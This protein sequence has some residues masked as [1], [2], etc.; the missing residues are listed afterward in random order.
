MTREDT[1]RQ[2]DRIAT[3]F[4]SRTLKTTKLLARGGFA[5]AK[6][7]LGKRG[8]RPKD[9][10]KQIANAER[11]LDELSGL[12][13]LLMKFGQMASYLDHSLPPEAQR[14]L[15]R[16]QSDSE[17]MGFESVASV[18][19]Q[20]L[21]GEPHE[22]FDSFEE[23]PFAAASIGQVHRAELDGQR[24]AVKVQYPGIVDAL[25]SD[26]KWVGRFA[27][28]G[29]AFSP[30]DGKGLAAELRD[31]VLEECDY[32]REAANQMLFHELFKSD[33]HRSVPRVIG[34]RSS[35]RVITTE[36][37]DG[38]RF[39]EFVEE[40]TP[41]ARHRAGTTIFETCFRSIF[42]NCVF[43]ADPHPG[44]YLFGKDGSVTFL[45]FGCLKWFAPEMI[46]GWKAV[47]LAL[48]DN[49]RMGFEKAVLETGM[50]A[51]P[52][53]FDW[54]YHWQAMDFLYAPFKSAE[55]TTYTGTFITDANAMMVFDN[56]NRLKL[57]LPPDWLFVN[58]LQFG[59]L[60]VLA[61]LGSTADWG[62]L[63]R[64]AVESETR[65]LQN[66]S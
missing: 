39:Q 24:V 8:G 5:F 13:G 25:D 1:V 19:R 28:L 50:V 48:L 3:G 20:E 62:A 36:F 44:N 55:P 49:D 60:S 14:V 10:A 21:G 57:A 45:D 15:A 61:Q 23:I 30:H 51:K 4:R 63:F 54:D 7:G 26:L 66:H 38:Q 9:A 37:V 12:K 53:G 35:G 29:L 22:L 11:M 33:S 16:L 42:G 31:R 18:I 41:E 47:A 40:A 46:D 56:P 64:S 58:R 6:R 2:L 32:R 52:K 27:R 34:E 43:N 17:P 65:P 59:L